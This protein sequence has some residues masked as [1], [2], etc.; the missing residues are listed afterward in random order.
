MQYYYSATTLGFYL[1]DIHGSNI[2]HD[3]VKITEDDYFSLIDGQSNGKVIIS[4]ENGYPIL[5]DLPELSL[6]E[7][8]SRL[9]QQR[10]LAYTQ[11]SDPL[12]FKAQRN[13]ISLSDWIAKIEEIKARYPYPDETQ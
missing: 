8:K 10:Q 5:A 4:N 1:D 13:E 6:D 9:K 12:F 7:I 11:E 2:P 3:S